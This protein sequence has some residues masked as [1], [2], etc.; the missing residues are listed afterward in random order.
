MNKILYIITGLGMGGAEKQVI[1]LSEEMSQRGHKVE[2]IA[3]KKRPVRLT[4]RDN[5]IIIHDLELDFSLISFLCSVRKLFDAINKISPD[6]IHS[7]MIHANILSRIYKAFHIKVPLIC[8]A[9]NTVEGGVLGMLL[10]RLT[11]KYCD[12]F[13]NVS[14]E[15]VDMF[16]KKKASSIGR[17][18]CIYNG[19]DTNRFS[20]D[21]GVRCRLRSE[22]SFK[23]DKKVLLSVGRFNEQKDYPNLIKAF[24]MLKNT[25]KNDLYRLLIIGDGP[26]KSD[27]ESLVE[28]YQLSPYIQFLGLRDDVEKIMCAADC[29]VLA[30]AWEGF[31][32]VVAEAMA[33]CL[34]VVATDSGGVSEVVGKH[35]PLVAPSD[36][37]ALFIAIQEVLSYEQ[38]QVYTQIV[39]ARNYIENNFSMKLICDN[40]QSI[41]LSVY[42]QGV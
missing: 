24:K 28:S 21:F 4:P 18:H 13:S 23:E 25:D 35:W 8:T 2:I 9:H 36:S 17:L 40:W 1:A 41:Y 33:C 31:G 37:D 29:F 12:F 3:L 32:L 19:I 16:Y 34:P 22:F 30:S 7:H 15:A 10:Y 5:N 14:N 20:F 39:S 6:I 42:M 38:T 11:Q 26:L 27:I